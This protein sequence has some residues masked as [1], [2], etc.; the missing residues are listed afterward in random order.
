MPKVSVLMPVYNTKE[1]YLRE[2]IE[3]ILNQTFT[4]FEFIILN[5]GS[6]DGNVERVVKSYTD[7]RIRYIRQDN[8]GIARSRNRLMKLAQGEYLA[9]TDHDDISHVDR[10][11]KQVRVLD[12][13]PNI[14]IVS[15]WYNVFPANRIVK[16]VENPRLFDFLYGNCQI[17]HPCAMMRK[18]FLEQYNLEYK[19][20]YPTAED[21]EL[22]TRAVR[23]TDMYNIQEV[24]FEYRDHDTQQS[25]LSADI[26]KAGAARASQNLLD[27]ITLD[28]DMQKQIH[29]W[30]NPKTQRKEKLLEKIF[31]LRNSHDKTHKIV[32]IFGMTLRFKRGGKTS[33]TEKNKEQGYV[34]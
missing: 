10:F 20:D 12:E 11:A 13:Y 22:W 5:D 27:F 21:Y 4:D 29:K 16:L 24:L 2:T 31:S 14:N 34:I 9:L 6:T 33:N 25:K 8:Q 1:E 32:K 3:S 19:L 7:N 17:L 26:Q 23:Y 28:A 30:F 18:S 15:A